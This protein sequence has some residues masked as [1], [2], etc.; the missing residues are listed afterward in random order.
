M[1]K[2]IQDE[3]RPQPPMWWLSMNH[4]LK[5]SEKIPVKLK[6]SYFSSKIKEDFPVISPTSLK[7]LLFKAIKRNFSVYICC[8]SLHKIQ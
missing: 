8:L 6:N 3:Q 1:G 5:I 7:F 4:D 2:N